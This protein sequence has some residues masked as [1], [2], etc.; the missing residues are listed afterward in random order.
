MRISMSSAGFRD[1]FPV[2]ANLVYFNHAAVGPLSVRACEAMEQFARDQ[3]DHGALHW[4]D[5]YAEY[6]RAR[7][8]AAK[9]IGA[10][11]AEIAILKNTS[12][13]LSFVAQG[14]RWNEGD[15]V[16]TTALEFPSN[17]TPWK[18]L[19]NVEVRVAGTRD[20]FTVDE[21]EARIDERT[22]LVTISSVAFHNGFVAELERI[23]DLCKR[24]GVLLCVDA[25]QH[26][27]MLPIDVRRA[28]VAFLA[29]D[30]HKWICGAEGAAIFYVAEEHREELEVLEVGWTNVVRKG[31]FLDCGTELVD[32][33]RRFE[34]GS[35]NTAGV[36]GLRAALDLLLEIGIETI[37]TEAIRV[38]TRLADGLESIGFRV[39]ARP[40]RSA[41]VG[42]TPPDVEK[43]SI[44]FLHRR[45]EEEGIVCAPREGMLRF[46]PHFYN[47]ESDVD[48]VVDALRRLTT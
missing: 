13:G 46:S 36:Y 38:A 12:E 45:L 11:A 24:R 31:S 20:G 25:I 42:A 22:R 18:R 40:V 10:T 5:W 3:R 17:W 37:S 9:L 7:E 15:N 14:M 27:G 32:T 35:L 41:I 6:D 8:S 29:A 34:A 28:N 44:L 48:R 2:T 33:A 39:A 1:L 23:G 16:V 26:A 19:A 47:D 30:G 4:R 43:T 21:I